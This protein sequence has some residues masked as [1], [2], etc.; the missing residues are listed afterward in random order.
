[1]SH[2]TSQPGI[3]KSWGDWGVMIYQKASKSMWLMGQKLWWS[4]TMW[5]PTGSCRANCAS[6]EKQAGGWLK[7]EVTAESSSWCATTANITFARPLLQSVSV[8]GIQY[9]QFTDAFEGFEEKSH[10]ANQSDL[11]GRYYWW[12]LPKTDSPT[13]S[14]TECMIFEWI[15]CTAPGLG[16]HKCR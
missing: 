12:V 4:C 2:I 6:T 7:K 14:T 9:A 16:Y 11:F 10:L 15:N 5:K 13:P 3:G 1:M 8:E